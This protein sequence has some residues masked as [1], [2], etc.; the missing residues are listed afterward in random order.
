MRTAIITG[1]ICLTV[2]VFSGWWAGSESTSFRLDSE[3]RAG[4]DRV[5]ELEQRNL[6]T[7]GIVDRLAGRLDTAKSIVDGI[8]KSSGTAIEKLRNVMANLRK[9]QEILRP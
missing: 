6:E 4:R 9:L 2:G 3:L 1:V 7:Q 5:I 8:S